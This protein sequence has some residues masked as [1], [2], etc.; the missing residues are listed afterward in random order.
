[1]RLGLYPCNTGL[2][3]LKP[4]R[5]D[6]QGSLVVMDAC[7]GHME[8]IVKLKARTSTIT[9]EM[10]GL[11]ESMARY[12]YLKRSISPY[13]IYMQQMSS[14]LQKS[15]F[16]MFGDKSYFSLNFAAML[17]TCNVR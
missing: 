3:R 6:H 12:L 7:V 15:G 5:L 17:N 14:T 16:A 2:D 8:L 4:S 1:M 9:T 11:S 13:G 10:R